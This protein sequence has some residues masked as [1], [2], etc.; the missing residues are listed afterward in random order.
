MQGM[1]IFALLLIST[2][3]LAVEEEEVDELDKEDYWKHEVEQDVQLEQESRQEE[4]EMKQKQRN[5]VQQQVSSADDSLQ[6]ADLLPQ[7]EDYLSLQPMASLPVHSSTRRNTS[8]P[9]VTEVD[10]GL[11][12]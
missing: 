11:G 3:S 10:L 2:R 9:N 1:I 7:V 4:K 5:H 8:C 6:G 12:S